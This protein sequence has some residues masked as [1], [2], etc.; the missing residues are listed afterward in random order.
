MNI[1]ALPSPGNRQGSEKEMNLNSVLIYGNI[2]SLQ[3]NSI[4]RTESILGWEGGQ[5]RTSL[6]ALTV[7]FI[8]PLTLSLFNST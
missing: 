3:D 8:W 7:Q 4:G 1:N 6:L 2:C 5:T